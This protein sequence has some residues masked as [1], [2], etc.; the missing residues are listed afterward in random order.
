LS[1]AEI[2][3]TVLNGNNSFLL[4][5]IIF[6]SALDAIL[7]GINSNVTICL[8]LLVTAAVSNYSEDQSWKSQ[9]VEI[10]VFSLKDNLVQELPLSGTANDFPDE[11]TYCCEEMYQ[12]SLVSKENK[13]YIF[14][15]GYYNWPGEG[16]WFDDFTYSFYEVTDS[17][18]NCIDSIRVC[19]GEIYDLL[20]ES[21]SGT[22]KYLQVYDAWTDTS[23]ESYFLQIKGY[24]DKYGVDSSWL[25]PYYDNLVFDVN[26]YGNTTY[27]SKTDNLFKP[28]SEMTQDV[29]T[30]TTIS[31]S[32][33]LTS[34]LGTQTYSIT[35]Y[36][37]IRAVLG[38]ESAVG[39]ENAPLAVQPRIQVVPNAEVE[40]DVLHVREVWDTYQ[41]SIKNSEFVKTELDAGVVA[42]YNGSDIAMIEVTAGYG[43]FSY[44]RIY[45][46]E[47]GK[48]IFAFFYNDSEENRLYIQADQLYRWR[49]TLG[50]NDPV[51]YDNTADNAA[52][53]SWEKT[54]VEEGNRLL[55][56]AN[57]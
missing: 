10:H 31:G 53:L 3:I 28:I 2:V 50:S 20:K 26:D 55:L 32:E 33:E 35:D 37:N 51:N 46:Y 43:A 54:A 12:V 44:A 6:I 38:T 22:S 36:T 42:Y 57:G 1:H 30:I 9:G 8:E 19:N 47:N 23:S 16:L 34:T 5:F 18:V 45:T 49:Y 24:F 52:Y 4:C 27:S 7:I 14:T 21:D 17:G 29:S 40:S 11:L 15:S 48:L 25:K 13:K 39:V 56:L 41:K